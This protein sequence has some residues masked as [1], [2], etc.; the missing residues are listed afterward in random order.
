MTD[1]RT[2]SAPGTGQLPPDDGY[3][4]RGTVALTL[5]YLLLTI[6]AWAYVYFVM[7]GRA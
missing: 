6:V 3:P 4:L 2:K 1:R 5:M 7:V